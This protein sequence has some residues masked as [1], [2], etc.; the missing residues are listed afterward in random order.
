MGGGGQAPDDRKGNFLD[1]LSWVLR[2]MPENV[3]A[4]DSGEHGGDQ[5]EKG[6]D[7]DKPGKELEN[8]EG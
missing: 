4:T 2:N 7:E 6:P 8:N 3:D 5:P 1:L